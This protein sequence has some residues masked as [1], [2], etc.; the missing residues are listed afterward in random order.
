MNDH[1][2]SRI[3]GRLDALDAGPVEISYIERDGSVWARIDAIDVRAE[4]TINSLAGNAQTAD[5][6]IAALWDEI[7]GLPRT[8]A[9]RIEVEGR[10]KRYARWTGHAWRDVTALYAAPPVEA[11]D[12]VPA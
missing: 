7:S 6:A 4:H 9:L 10:A 5:D 8:H 3:L 2:I 1:P 11:G 12:E